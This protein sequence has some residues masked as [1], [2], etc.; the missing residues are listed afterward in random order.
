MNQK[1]VQEVDHI[2]TKEEEEWSCDLCTLINRPVSKLCEACMSP[3]PRGESIQKPVRSQFLPSSYC[4]QSDLSFSLSPSAGRTDT[5]NDPFFSA[6]IRFPHNTFSKPQQEVKLH[7]TAAF[8]NTTLV[9]SD[10]GSTP[11]APPSHTTERRSG[12]KRDSSSAGIGTQ[13]TAGHMT[14][15]F[16]SIPCKRRKTESDGRTGG[17]QRDGT[18]HT[19]A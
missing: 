15:R 6:L 16:P 2:A 8:G 7:R 10:L 11:A 17:A 3:R 18:R 14:K 9:L 1:P 19:S 4:N 12:V 5:A 13:P